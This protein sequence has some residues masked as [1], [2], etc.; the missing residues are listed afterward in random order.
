MVGDCSRAL[1]GI[2]GIA[3]LR[4]R[5]TRI[6]CGLAR[7]LGRRP[8]GF[9][10]HS[11]HLA[12]G[13]GDFGRLPKLFKLLPHSLRDAAK[14]LA[15]AAIHLVCYPLQLGYDAV[16]LNGETLVVGPYAGGF[17]RNAEYLGGLP[18]TLCVF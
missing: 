14:P 1:C 11:R 7:L 8:G 18:L 5:P 13:S 4:G 9:S 6:C 12:A 10:R 15:V 16:V 3:C 17:R 2:C